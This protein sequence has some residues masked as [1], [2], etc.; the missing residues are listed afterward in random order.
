MRGLEVVPVRG[1]WRLIRL[2]VFWAPLTVLALWGGSY[3]YACAMALASP[4]KPLSLPLKTKGGE[5]LLRA[6]SFSFDLGRGV[7]SARGASLLD[8]QG[9]PIGEAD[10]LFLALPPDTGGTSRSVDVR[11]QG[12][13]LRVR[14]GANGRIRLLDYLPVADEEEVGRPVSVL[15]EG[16]ELELEDAAGESPFRDVLHVRSLTFDGVGSIWSARL[17]VR[18]SGA[19]ESSVVAVR[20][21]ARASLLVDVE[22]RG[23]DLAPA[24]RW[25]RSAPEARGVSLL[26][27]LTAGS[28]TATG[29]FRGRFEEG[30]EPE[31]WGR[32]TWTGASVTYLKDYR[33]QSVAGSAEFDRAGIR[34][35]ARAESGGAKAEWSGSVR[36]DP[37]VRSAGSVSARFETLRDL[38]IAARKS[39]PAE[40]GLAGCAFDGSLAFDEARGFRIQGLLAGAAARWKDE[41]V[42]GP[43]A[44]IALGRERLV[45]HLEKGAWRG[46]PVQ[47]WI[48][49]RM[50]SETLKGRIGVEGLDLHSLSAELGVERI[51][52]TGALGIGVE[53]A[54]RN[55]RV[56]FQGDGGLFVRIGDREPV[57]LG[58]FDVG[59]AWRDGRIAVDR[60]VL[61]GDPGVLTA[62]GTVDPSRSRVDLRLRLTGVGLG[63]LHE[64]LEGIGSGELA[65]TGALDDPQVSGRVELYSSSI[66][67]YDI[68]LVAA[69]IALNRDRLEV[70]SLQGSKG[71]SWLQG[72]GAWRFDTGAVSGVLQATG[73]SLS[74]IAGA[75]FSGSLGVPVASLSGTISQPVLEFEFDGRELVARGVRVDSVRGRGSL[76]EGVLQVP[77]LVARMDGGVVTA[78]GSYGI[79]S[80]DGEAEARAE[81]LNLDRLVPIL[82]GGLLLSGSV[83]STVRASF[84][85]GKLSGLSSSGQVDALRVNPTL[86][87]SGTWAVHLDG[88]VWSGE[89]EVGQLERFVRVSEFRLDSRAG[90]FSGGVEAFSM[91]I[92][93]VYQ[94]VRPYFS[95]ERGLL[96]REAIRIVP[97]LLAEF[98]RVSGSLDL[99]AKF[100]GSL[101]DPT[102]D[103]DSLSLSRLRYGK[104]NAGDVRAKFSRLGRTWLIPSLDWSG[105]PGTLQASGTVEEGGVIAVDGNLYNFDAN[106]LAN[107]D[108][109]FA[110]L[111]G[112]ADLVS[113][114][115]EGATNSPE[116]TASVNGR[117]FAAPKASEATSGA[118]VE[119]SAP[120]SLAVNL[121]EVSIREGAVTLAGGISLRGL[122]ATVGGS[123]PFRYPFEIPESEPIA[124]EVQLP[125]RSISELGEFLPSLDAARTE[126][127]LSATLQLAGP[128][129]DVQ[130]R[131]TASLEANRIAVTGI[132]T[133]ATSVVAKGAFDGKSAKFEGEATSS[134]GGT[135]SIDLGVALADLARLIDGSVES[136]WD[137]PISGGARLAE[138]AVFENR[139]RN[140]SAQFSLSGSLG[141]SGTLRRPVVATS[142]PL[143][144]TN[145]DGLVPA[146]FEAAT[147]AAVP[148]IDPRFAVEFRM[149]TEANPA[150]IRTGTG[151]FEVFGPGA[152]TGTLASPNLLASMTVRAGTIRLPNAR[153]AIE[154]G[155]SA[156]LLYRGEAA[157]QTAPRL[158]VDLRGRTSLTAQRFDGL[159]GRYDILLEIRGNLLEE[160]QMQILA[161]SDPPDLSQD[162]I[163]ALL[164]QGDILESIGPQPGDTGFGKGVGNVLSSIA[165]PLVLDPFTE[166]LARE[167]GLEFLSFEYNA[168]E[169][170][171]VTAAKSI[172]K[173]LVLQYRRQV[174]EPVHGI[175]MYDLRLAYRPF[176]RTGFWRNV[177][178]SVGADQERPYKISIE[179]GRRF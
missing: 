97:E 66:R 37:D 107:L 60:L 151:A 150:R 172:G 112:V 7:L 148:F 23:M 21:G 84:V 165:L 130:I 134:L 40:L 159:V 149:G 18:R 41:T 17:D 61:Q 137:S 168:F 14:R 121:Y 30:R 89:V 12:A 178:F 13:R 3:F 119:T 105:G 25:L 10:R 11:V 132:Q 76:R 15:V 108:V 63:A 32:A 98:D 83:D 35:S 81:G 144:I 110:K 94:A 138:I 154:R 22:A 62:T 131:G 158:D 50:D 19:A 20:R 141:L 90:T 36:W 24:L 106:W 155:G 120:T 59:G 57:D 153:I 143:A 51:S 78:S 5:V 161:N 128:R 43:A 104:A 6:R 56:T 4:G 69:E 126:G 160:G 127:S 52:G 42:A 113:F 117:L 129:G 67:G 27:D 133:T 33:A 46:R 55:P 68:P 164:G 91:P 45:A 170:A 44:R 77:Q 95:G 169:G 38:P 114:R 136:I 26:D 100:S 115:A 156:R 31:F 71:A 176:T 74:E 70:G 8:P 109:R 87:G 9:E 139:G 86:V 53:G 39:I 88:D 75:D 103:V 125:K 162:R 34:G 177:F 49:V 146:E 72:Q 48:E 174:A 99:G 92:Q 122:K 102:L 173:G 124:L 28:V 179:Y 29:T 73:M 167:F 135:L 142:Q 80:N 79:E 123:I 140:G 147:A 166:R 118:A 58:K 163:L 93:D 1:T 157:E 47:G 65:A 171:V 64:S 82:P 145:A 96:G 16:L 152:L 85:G 175:Q 116:I 111:N 2:V 54:W 101:D